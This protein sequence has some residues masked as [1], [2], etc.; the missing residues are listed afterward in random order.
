MSSMLLEFQ[1]VLYS[2]K[3]S[4]KNIREN[5]TYRVL[6]KVLCNFVLKIYAKISPVQVFRYT[7]YNTHAKQLLTQQLIAKR[8]GWEDQ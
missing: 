6:E 7:V 8:C 4:Q 2:G 1:H 3:C 5:L